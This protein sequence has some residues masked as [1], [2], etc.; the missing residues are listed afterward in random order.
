MGVTNDLAQSG[1]SGN[2]RVLP[3]LP[4]LSGLSGLV[5]AGRDIKKEVTNKC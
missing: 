3:G 1:Y 2:I 4:V 5:E